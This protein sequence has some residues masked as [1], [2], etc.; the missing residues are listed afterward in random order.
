MKSVSI[1][2]GYLLFEQSNK[3]FPAKGQKAKED[4]ARSLQIEETSES[5]KKV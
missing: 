4:C 2:G 3:T 5:F 1:S